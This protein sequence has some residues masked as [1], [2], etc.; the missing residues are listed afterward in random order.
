MT[1][2]EIRE[3]IRELCDEL[4]Q[5]ARR[6]MQKGLRKVILPAMLGAGL[7]LSAGGCG[8]RQPIP[9]Q[10]DRGTVAPYGAIN[11]YD[12][13]IP[14]QIDRGPVAHYGVIAPYDGNPPRP[15]G[16]SDVAY[17]VPTVDS[18]AH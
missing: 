4:D 7:A 14:L 15:D 13:T 10:I 5:G 17:G 16:G 1:E 2:R 12:G 8:D 18:K 9:P 11:P 6:V 3:V